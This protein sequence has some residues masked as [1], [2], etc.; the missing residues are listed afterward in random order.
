[1]AFLH[2]RQNSSRI[3]GIGMLSIKFRIVDLLGLSHHSFLSLALVPR[4]DLSG[5]AD[6]GCPSLSRTYSDSRSQCRQVFLFSLTARPPLEHSAHL[7]DWQHAPE[8]DGPTNPMYQR[9]SGVG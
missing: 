4:D 1:M 2:D 7:F 3:Q 5:P 8:A 9:R 6:F